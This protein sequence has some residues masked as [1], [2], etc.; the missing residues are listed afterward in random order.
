MNAN[1]IVEI[2]TAVGGVL[3]LFLIVLGGVLGTFSDEIVKIIR[4]IKR[5]DD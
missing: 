5:K 4:E 1:D 3:F 2:I